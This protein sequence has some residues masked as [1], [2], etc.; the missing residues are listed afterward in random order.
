MN[1][2]SVKQWSLTQLVG[3]ASEEGGERGKGGEGGEGGKGGELA[4]RGGGLMEQTA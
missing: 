4:A 3:T 2:R 1:A